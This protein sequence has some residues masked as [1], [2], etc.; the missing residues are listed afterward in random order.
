MLSSL[1]FNAS[2]TAD[3]G[4]IELSSE[5][6]CYPIKKMHYLIKTITYKSKTKIE[7]S[8]STYVASFKMFPPF[9]FG[10]RVHALVGGK[11]T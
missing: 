2:I 7:N 10:H 9:E 11:A 6:C 3:T 1:L 8:I 5:V 4:S